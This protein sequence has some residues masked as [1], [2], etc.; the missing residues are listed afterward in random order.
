M[1]DDVCMSEYFRLF[2]DFLVTVEIF[3]QNFL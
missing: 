3:R 1:Y 2:Y